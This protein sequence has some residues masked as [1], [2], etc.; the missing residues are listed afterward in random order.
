MLNKS[1]DSQTDKAQVYRHT[2]ANTVGWYGH[3]RQ[4]GKDGRGQDRVVTTQYKK[5]EIITYCMVIVT[6]QDTFV[7][8]WYEIGTIVNKIHS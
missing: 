1:S 4:H 7:Q 6:T 5:V 8:H 3:C 2:V